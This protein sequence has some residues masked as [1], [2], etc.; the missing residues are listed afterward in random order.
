MFIIA[1]TEA[2]SSPHF[3][4]RTVPTPRGHMLPVASGVQEFVLNAPRSAMRWPLVDLLLGQPLFPEACA[5]G[6]MTFERSLSS[7]QISD[8]GP[9]SFSVRCDNGFGIVNRIT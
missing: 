4:E 7:S 5:Q 1:E 9:S 2:M 8:M 6:A 3:R